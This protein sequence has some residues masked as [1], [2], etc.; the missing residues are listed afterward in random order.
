MA[1]IALQSPFEGM[2][3]HMIGYITSLQNTICQGLE[4]F[5]PSSRFRRDSWQRDGGGGGITAV[6][7]NGKIFEKGGVNISAVFGSLKTQEEQQ[8]FAQ[9]IQ[10]Q[11]HDNF[12]VK[13]AIFFATGLSLVIH[14]LN[15]HVPT[16]HMNYRYF[17]IQ[18]KSDRLW[19][20]GG[21]TDLTPYLLYEEDCINFHAQLKEACDTHDP[22]YYPSFKQRCDSYFY[23]KHRQE[24]RGIGGIFFDHLNKNSAKHYFDLVQSCGNAFLP[25]YTAIVQKR[26]ENPYTQDQQDWQYQRRGRYV[27]FNL[28]YDKGT[29]FGL[30]TGGRIESILMSL[31]KHCSW[32]YN[33]DIPESQKP[34]INIL[35]TPRSW[36]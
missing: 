6:I 33:P 2:S 31:P 15:P 22:Q 26:H 3:Q 36:G 25:S 19:W 5:E 35:K 7:E 16:V 12:D 8:V 20:F 10:Q 32:D 9:L 24:H 30:K 28:V 23:I 27:E 34:L 21:G 14:P 29:L 18:S 1:M 4:T 11:G 13:E 17:E